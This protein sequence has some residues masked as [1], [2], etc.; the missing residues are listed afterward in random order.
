MRDPATDRAVIDLNRCFSEGTAEAIEHF[1]RAAKEACGGTQIAGTYYGYMAAHGARQ[2]LCGHNALGR[3]LDCPDVDLLMSPNMYAHRELGGTSTFMSATESVRLHG[4]LWFDESDLRT[5]LSP[6]AAGY[7]RTDTAEQS[8]AVTWRE[9]ANVL[10]RR[11]AVGWFDMDGGWFSD[12]PMW[13]CYRRQLQVS[14]EA[15][16]RREPF[17][18]EVALFVDEQSYDYYRFSELTRRMVMDTVANMPHAGVT[19]DLYLLPDVESPS[20]PHYR[21]YVV[22]NAV[23]MSEATREALYRQAARNQAT[24]LLLYAPG[25]A[26]ERDLDV[27]RLAHM[28]GMQLAVEAGPASPDYRLEPG[29]PLARGPD[30]A[31]PLCPGPELAPRPVIMDSEAEVIGRFADTGAV[32]LARKPDRG[33]TVLY[34]SSVNVP[35]PLL[36]AIAREAGAHVYTESGDSLYTDGQYLALHAAS[37]GTKT[38]RLPDV[39]RVVDAVTGE[40]IAERT[41][42]ISRD[43]RL[44]E[45]LFVWLDKP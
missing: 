35:A 41:D 44:G 9:F 31:Q 21:L 22:L 43:M 38:V 28:T 7:G 27:S 26:G 32:A 17:V 3:V 16:G 19:W 33:V 14:A 15:F 5:Y 8:V 6:T 2:Q 12:A 37:D 13:D 24:V 25:Y 1:A 40:L 11:A 29:H 39:R 34:C 36:R 45:T 4:K 23:S 20:L 42:T 30:P 10:T 18:G